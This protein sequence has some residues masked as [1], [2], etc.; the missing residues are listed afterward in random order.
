VDCRAAELTAL[1][2]GLREP[3]L[4]VALEVSALRDRSELEHWAG[5]LDLVATVRLRMRV[6]YP[7]S[8]GVRPVFEAPDL[9][10]RTIAEVLHDAGYRGFYEVEF[11][12]A[13]E[14]AGA[15]PGSD[16]LVELLLAARD[17]IRAAV[18]PLLIES[19]SKKEEGVGA[20]RR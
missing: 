13:G 7:L 4:R 18:R 11:E 8:E 10:L 1:I 17:R 2:D 6:A 9:D 20:G 19:S 5:R 3:T 14:A 12:A 16:P 15:A